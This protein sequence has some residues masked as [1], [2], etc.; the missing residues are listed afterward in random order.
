LAKKSLSYFKVVRNLNETSNL[1]FGISSQSKEVVV[2]LQEPPV[3]GSGM[4]TAIQ[5]GGNS[6]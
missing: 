4:N 1:Q 2:F 6:S 5:S 3:S